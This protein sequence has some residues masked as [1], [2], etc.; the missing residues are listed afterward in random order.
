MTNTHTLR[1]TERE[2]RKQRK[3]KRE[4]RREARKRR[5]SA[6][7]H[8]SMRCQQRIPRHTA[9][10]HSS[11]MHTSLARIGTESDTELQHDHEF[12][13]A[14]R[15]MCARSEGEGGGALAAA[16]LSHFVCL[17]IVE[18]PSLVRLLL[19]RR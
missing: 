10:S 18:S 4:E 17:P 6:R 15:V 19:L 7:A 9:P 8:T 12:V 16:V 5:E 3:E 2:A 14:E 11:Y 1:K 13:Y